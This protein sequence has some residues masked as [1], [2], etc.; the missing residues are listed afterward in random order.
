M[1]VLLI[2]P[3]VIN[4]IE[5]W[6][7]KHKYVR[8]ALAH[9]AGYLRE[10]IDVEIKVID[11]KYQRLQF[12][13]VVE[14]IDDFKPNIVGLTAFTSEIK[15]AAY[16]AALT[17]KLNPNILTVIGGVHVSTLPKETLQIKTV[18]NKVK[19]K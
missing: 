16:L 8:T 15:P 17:K 2:N 7:D 12:E 9:L 14:I 11:A 18:N 5:P 10:K 3:P 6:T 1:K 19:S 4:V 13:E